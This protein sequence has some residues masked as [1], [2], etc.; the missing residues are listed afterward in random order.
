MSSGGAQKKARHDPPVPAEPIGVPLVDAH[1]HL[2]AIA[3]RAGQPVTAEHVAATMAAAHAA[4]VA[5][6]V[7]VGDT[8]AASRWAVATANTR[9]DVVAAVAVHPTEVDELEGPDGEERYAELLAL[10]RDPR[11]VAVGETGLD[12]HWDR[13]TPEAQQ[14]HFRRHVQLA[15]EVGKPL[16]IHD[17]E[18]HDDVL[19]IV[20]EEGVPAAGVVM[21]S[22]SGDVTFARRCVDLGFVLSFSGVATFTNASG[23]R[24]AAAG[25][26]LEQ[27]L[28]E[29]D[30]PFLTPHPFRGRPNAPE[31]LGW[32]ARG[33]AADRGVDPAEVAAATT[34]TA[35]RL[36]PVLS[37][38]G[39][40][41]GF[42]D[43]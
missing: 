28:V 8:L 35:A 21:H 4:G 41:R 27:I 12:Y 23:V 9:D 6:V 30:A 13:T 11:C 38:S 17:R 40:L 19:R 32:T 14:R 22:F 43:G 26:P 20:V 42:L 16:M 33:L 2:D 24:E 36:F 29:T 18:A 39:N 1:T 3:Q 31:L 37:G 10:A 5:A 34:A 25:T 7:T 15:H